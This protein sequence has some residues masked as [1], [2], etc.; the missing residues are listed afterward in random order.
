MPTLGWGHYANFVSQVEFGM[1]M[2]AWGLIALNAQQELRKYNRKR[3]ERE[4]WRG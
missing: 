1:F 2:V 4:E 3:K